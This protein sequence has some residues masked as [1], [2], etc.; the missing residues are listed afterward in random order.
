MNEQTTISHGLRA[1]GD[2]A[3]YDAACKRL[4]S[5]KSILARI[6]QSCLEEYKDCDVE[7][8]ERCIEGNPLID[9]IAL[10]SDEGRGVID[11]MD[12][13]D[14]SLYEGTV[15]FDI[16]FRA[17]VP[18]TEDQIALIINVEAQNKFKPGYPLVKRGI[19]Y[20]ARMIS[21]QYAREFKQSHYEKIKKVYS[22][23]ICRHPDEEWQ[24]TI[25][26]YH[27]VEENMVGDAK[28]SKVNYDLLSVIMVCLKG[29]DQA[30]YDGVIRMLDVLLS[31]DL[32]E[33]EKQ[34][35]LGGDYNIPMTDAIEKELAMTCNLSEGIWEEGWEAGKAEGL[36]KGKAEGLAE[37][38][39]NL[40]E[41]MGWSLDQS[42]SALKIPPE[43]KEKYA[44]LLR[45]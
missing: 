6:M 11:G 35:V 33:T 42:M 41:A 19:Y 9:S 18:N 14:A 10:L 8:I 7:S 36:A 23:W 34:N 17:L 20:C 24:S 27:L 3:G 13:V 4:L 37:S 45:Q 43:E 44:N 30:T 5:E 26:R 38:L 1:T 32:T 2:K 12:T 21:S 22:I 31:Q 28:E 29:R 40:M 39:K 25:T 15:T 16:R